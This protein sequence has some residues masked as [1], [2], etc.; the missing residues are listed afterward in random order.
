MGIKL[1]S[2]DKASTPNG[3]LAGVKGA[4]ANL[5]INPPRVDKLGNDTMLDFG[6]ALLNEKPAFAFPK[7]KNLRENKTVA[8]S[9]N[10]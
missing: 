10:Q 4:I 7:A 3:F 2:I 9:N 1:A 6:Y 5:F 8:I